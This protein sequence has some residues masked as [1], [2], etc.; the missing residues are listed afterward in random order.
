MTRN[1]PW[2]IAL[3]ALAA[4]S[5][6][7]CDSLPGRPR[8]AD[9]Y[10]LPS[11]ILDFASLYDLRCA[12]CHGADGSLGPARN[13]NDPLYIAYAGHTAI[14]SVIANGVPGTAMPSFL[15][16]TGGPLTAAQVDALADG[17]VRKWGQ[18]ARYA[19]AA[20]PP[21]SQAA[22]VTGDPQRGAEAFET[23][24]AHCHGSGG[25]G[26]PEA[27]SVVNSAFLNLVSD[28][29][30][31]TTVVVG[32]RDLG[33]P[34]FDGYVKGRNLTPQEVSDIVAWLVAQRSE[35]PGQPYAAGPTL[36]T[37]A[38]KGKGRD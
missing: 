18:P 14:R 35:F 27:G 37:G 21:S 11:E 6:V 24:C 2:T 38:E 3:V 15:D 34:G 12:G 9:R 25:T 10:R 32:R 36:G 16:S 28:R 17:I 8:E 1:R 22:S 26:G 31:R 7:A 23:A 29:S 33:M 4:V 5:L 19:A 30:L 20:L 13:L